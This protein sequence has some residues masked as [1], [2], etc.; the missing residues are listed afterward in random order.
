MTLPAA[1]PILLG[2]AL[3]HHLKKGKPVERITVWF[4]HGQLHQLFSDNISNKFP[5]EMILAEGRDMEQ[6]IDCRLFEVPWHIDLTKKK[7]STTAPAPR[8][9]EPLTAEE[10]SWH[11]QLFEP[12]HARYAT[13]YRLLQKQVRIEAMRRMLRQ[14]K[15]QP[16][17]EDTAHAQ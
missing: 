15:D 11:D 3:L 7:Q 10:Q 14:R 1:H 16:P 4:T 17:A 9:P 13:E 6:K 2:P 8:P 12:F 5:L